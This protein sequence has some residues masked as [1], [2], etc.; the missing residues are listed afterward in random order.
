[1]VVENPNCTVNNF[2]YLVDSFICYPYENKETEKLFIEIVREYKKS[3]GEE[4]WSSF[5][6]K[7]IFL[8]AT[9]KKIQRLCFN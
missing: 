2:E 6:G 7:K 3:L 4:R 8:P 9:V 1:M 5:L